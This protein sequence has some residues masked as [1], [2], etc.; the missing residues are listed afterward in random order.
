MLDESDASTVYNVSPLIFQLKRISYDESGKDVEDGVYLTF[1]IIFIVPFGRKDKVSITVA[2]TVESR[3]LGIFET[4]TVPVSIFL[5]DP[6]IGL[7]LE[8]VELSH[9]ARAIKTEIK[10]SFRYLNMRIS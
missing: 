1:I 3:V 6:T 10:L 8:E 9:D 4:V 7:F 2:N 5:Q